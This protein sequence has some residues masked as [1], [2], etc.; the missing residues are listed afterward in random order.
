MNLKPSIAPALLL[1]VLA[2][3]GVKE[4][5]YGRGDPYPAGRI[6]FAQTNLQKNTAVGEVV[7]TRSVETN[8]L[9]VTVPIRAATK[10]RLYIQYQGVFFNEAGKEVDRTAWMT[11][12]LD[13]NL[14]DEV[15]VS[16]KTPS[17]ADYRVDFRY[18]ATDAPR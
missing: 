6:S 16:S 14:F 5:N 9:T 4:P 3:C 2:G 18:A 15:Q 10:K 12:V 13:P 8:L 1:S 17:A 11:K 7:A